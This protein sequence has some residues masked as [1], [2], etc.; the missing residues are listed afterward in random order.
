LNHD[1]IPDVQAGPFY[2]LG[3]DFKVARELYPPATINVEGFVESGG[4][5]QPQAGA[6]VHGSYP[7]HFQSYIHDLNGDGWNDV[8]MMMAFGPR[9]TFSG[10][11]FLNPRGEPRHWD[12]YEVIKVVPNEINPWADIDGDGRPELIGQLGT[13]A[14]WTDN[15]WG[16]WKP[17]WSNATKAWTFTAISEKRRWGGH[18][19]GVGDINGDGRIDIVGPLGWWEQPPAGTTGLWKFHQVALGR[20]ELPTG[21]GSG[22]SDMSVYDVNGDGLADVVTSIAAH[23]PGLAWFEQKKD[24]AFER[25]DIMGAPEDRKSPAGVAFAELHSLTY[26]DM[27]GD[28]LKDIIAGKDWY[29][30]G[31]VYQ[32]NEIDNPAVLYWFRLVRNP[33]A[34]GGAEFLPEMI[35]NNSGIGHQFTN[36]D[37]NGDGAPD[38]LTSAR[39]GTFVFFNNTRKR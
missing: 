28:G 3:P 32:E 36:A 33:K 2:Y 38:I 13:R 4:P 9:P 10:H 24:G 31:F 7:P 29:S 5:E 39:R 19:G 20:P 6:I 15:Q 11:V 35:H 8:V 34:P 27:D 37:M 17:D 23:G 21:P 1:G 30:H 18:G 12:N 22:G 26:A 25:H 14:D 16:Y